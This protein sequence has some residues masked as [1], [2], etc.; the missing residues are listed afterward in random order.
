MSR[1]VPQKQAV[2]EGVKSGLSGLPVWAAAVAIAVSAFSAGLM[3]P[4][5]SLPIQAIIV[6]AGVFPLAYLLLRGQLRIPAFPGWPVAACAVVF[7]LVSCA[8][9]VSPGRSVDRMLDIL[10][11]AGVFLA[12]ACPGPALRARRVLLGA[13]ALAGLV[14][15]VAAGNEY[16]AHA[17][18]GDW[19]WRVFGTF[20]NPGYLSGFLAVC[21]PATLAL[22]VT[23]PERSMAFA[24]GFAAVVQMAVLPLTGAR[25]G[26]LA[27]VAALGVFVVLAAAGRL[28]DRKG[29]LRLAAIVLAAMLLGV[30]TQRPTGQR[31][32]ASSQEGHSFQFRQF[33]WRSTARMALAR[34]VMGFGPGSFEVAYHP[35]AIAGYTRMA[36]ST[37]LQTAAESGIPAAA[38]LFGAC[39]TLA[40]CGAVRVVRRQEPPADGLLLAAAL[41]GCAATGVRGLFDSDWWCLPSLLVSATYAGMLAWRPQPERSVPEGVSRAGGWA[42][43]LAGTA[44]CVLLVM[45][46]AAWRN[47]SLAGAAEQTG[48]FPQAL[49]CWRQAAADAPWNAT[50]RLRAARLA[51][52]MSPDAYPADVVAELRRLTRLEPTNPRLQ[53]VLADILFRA[54]RDREGLAALAAA[55]RLDPQSPQLLREEASVL[56]RG[57]RHAEALERWREMVRVEAAPYGRVRAIPQMVEPSYAWAHAALGDELARQGRRDAAASEWRR[58][59][60]ILNRYFA[61]LKELRPVLEAAGQTDPQAEEEG[62]ALLSRLQTSLRVRR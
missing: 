2:P 60:E 61:S 30:V 36:H 57:G 46:S 8:F 25:A 39:A 20:F 43:A 54:R 44:A 48:D 41:A 1:C 28:P 9:T 32:E 50:T 5:S 26:L 59:C 31:V 33:T 45:S 51:A 58:A 35:F 24:L 37:Y 10:A 29:W 23:W 27:L 47:V 21:V 14:A 7:V 17:R 55:R 11:A 56:E 62:K 19:A 12:A 15:A 34:P 6:V 16:A 3:Q 38:L 49:Q 18:A 4:S 53:T 13:V 22:A 42:L 40:V 52:A